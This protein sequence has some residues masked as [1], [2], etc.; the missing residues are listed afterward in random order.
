MTYSSFYIILFFFVLFF[1]F[2]FFFF[3][4]ED[5]IRDLT[6]TGVQTCALPILPSALVLVPT[7]ELAM[8]VSEAIHRYGKPLGARVLPIYGGAPFTQQ[9][10]ALQ[11]G[12][13][14]VVATP[15]RALDHARR[16]TLPLSGL[17]I[18]V[19]DEADEMLDMGFA[20]D[21]EAIL[22]QTP[23]TRQTLLFSATLPPR[24]LAVAKRHLRNPVEIKIARER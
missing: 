6:V 20:E 14:V 9:L 5:G 19:L 23:T 18:V 15:G 21:L 8:Q 10:R 13:D 1:F 2:F 7:R 24:I 3:Q 16:G 12:V 11:R 17:R 22:S 4:A